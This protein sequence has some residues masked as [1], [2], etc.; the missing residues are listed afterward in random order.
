MPNRN[1]TGP[2]GQGSKT[3]RGMGNCSDEVNNQ[4]MKSRSGGNR[5]NRNMFVDE[6]TKLP[7]KELLL[8][9]KAFLENALKDVE[10]Q[11]LE[12]DQK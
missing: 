7:T 6:N 2:L 4:N 1:G 9:Q 3:G 5:G 8:E 11:L 12:I 10:K